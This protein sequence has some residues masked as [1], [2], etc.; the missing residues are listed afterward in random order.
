MILIEFL[1]IVLVTAVSTMIG[2]FLIILYRGICISRQRL[3]LVLEASVM[4]AISIELMIQGLL[5]NWVQAIIGFIIG[6]ALIFLINKFIPHMHSVVKHLSTLIV[7]GFLIHKIPEGMAMGVSL[8]LDITFG[9][10]TAFLIGLQNFPEGA[11]VAF[12]MVL[13]GKPNHYIIKV[14]LL[15][16]VLFAIAAIITYTFLQKSPFDSLL[17]TIAAGAMVYLVYEE[18]AIS[19]CNKLI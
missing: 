4:V 18:I 8:M 19:R 11:I 13:A 7:V 6:L 16:Q 10:I 1:L 9:L 5:I 14:V 2:A 17:L 15:T 3:L 12:P